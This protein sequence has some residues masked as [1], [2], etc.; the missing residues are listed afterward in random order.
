[1]DANASRPKKRGRR[2]KFTP[3]ERRQRYEEQK[4]RFSKARVHI[5][6]KQMARWAR[7]KASLRVGLKVKVTDED[8]AKVLLDR[9]VV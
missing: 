3:E 2:P 7:V 6:V 8:V 1:M 5:G 9:L 4:Q